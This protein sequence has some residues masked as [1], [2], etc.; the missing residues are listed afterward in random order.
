[1]PEDLPWIFREWAPIEFHTSPLYAAL[2]PLVAEDPDLLELVAARNPGVHPTV[3]FFGA[4]HHLV[5]DAPDEELAAFF[6]S[7]AGDDARP[8]GEAAPAFQAFCAAHLDELRHLVRTRFVQT[9]IARRAVAL[10]FA[11]THVVADGPVDLVEVGA[12]AGV[13]LSQHRFRLRLGDQV[14]GP[15]DAAIDVASEWRADG[16][17]PDLTR[18]PS[19]DQRIAVDRHPVD[20]TSADDRRWL[21]ALVWPENLAQAHQ[22]EAALGVVAEDPPRIVAGDIG[23][24]ADR[25]AASIPDGR[26]RVVFHA[27]T[28]GHVPQDQHQAFDDA[29]TRVGRNGPLTVLSMET[30]APDQPGSDS[31][32]PHF[33]LTRREDDGP[34]E[35]LAFVEA[36]GAWIEPVTP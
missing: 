11:L 16:P 32:D 26:P 29:V 30:R 22:L 23:D 3:L 35:V 5:L 9:N 14:V 6:P 36:H 24:V 13:L 28:R 33:V 20:P 8:P 19:I 10:R 12:S 7:V 15:P 21:R 1:M 25:V 18:V 27:A 2:S 31:S 34:A 4:V 17:A